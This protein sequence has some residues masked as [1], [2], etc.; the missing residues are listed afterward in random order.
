MQ[1]FMLYAKIHRAT[2]AQADLH[3]VG[4]LTI[5]RDLM[6]AAGLL[7]RQDLGRDAAKP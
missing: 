3:H 4:S 6:G 1:R 2:V 7:L 5:D